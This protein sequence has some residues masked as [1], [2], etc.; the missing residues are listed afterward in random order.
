LIWNNIPLAAV[1]VLSLEVLIKV[2]IMRR[3]QSTIEY[4]LVIGALAASLIIMG[5]Y[6]KRGFQGNVRGL[7]DQI[8]EQYE[9]GRMSI[10]N[11]ETVTVIDSETTEST[12]SDGSLASQDSDS[13]QRQTISRS[14][15]E[16]IDDLR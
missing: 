7:S 10:N 3:A 8:G 2:N 14:I 4:I 12:S 1:R 5:A 6:M 16:R 9:P 13:E 15:Q 11:I